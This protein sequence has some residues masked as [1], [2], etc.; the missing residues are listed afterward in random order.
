M[1]GVS[2]LQKDTTVLNVY[3]PNN[4]TLKYMKQKLTDWKEEIDRSIIITG[5]FSTPL[6]KTKRENQ[7]GYIQEVKNT[8]NKQQSLT[9]MYRTFHPTTAEYTLFSIACGNIDKNKPYCGW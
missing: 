9:D 5:N 8:I 6:N 7:Q 1:I 2:I 4:R 3:V